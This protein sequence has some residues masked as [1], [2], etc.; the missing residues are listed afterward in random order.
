M[1]TPMTIQDANSAYKLKILKLVETHGNASNIPAEQ[2]RLASEELRFHYCVASQPEWTLEQV[3]RHYSI[4]KRVAISYVG[5]E[6]VEATP[7]RKSKRGEKYASIFSYV[8]EHIFEQVT[9]VQI[10]QVGSIS[11]QTAL[12]VIESRPDVFRKIKRGL[13]ELRDAQ[14]DRKAE[15]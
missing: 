1:K 8:N 7:E 15:K 6:A 2:M 5:E 12:K 9:P 13:Y 14:E 3:I 10:S 11:Y 4:D